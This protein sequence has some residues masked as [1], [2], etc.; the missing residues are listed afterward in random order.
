MSK[1]NKELQAALAPCRTAFI[2]VAVMSCIVNVLYLSGSFFMLEV[3]DRVIPSRSVPTLV[4]LGIILAVLYLFQA[5]IDIVRSR[6]L[7][8][9][10]RALDAAISPRLF[11]AMTL[12]AVNSGLKIDASQPGRDFDNVKSF[13]VGGGPSAFF[14]LPWM[15]IYIVICYLFHPALGAMALLGA[16]ILVALTR[17]TEVGTRDAAK[18]ATQY[19][20]QRAALAEAG[21]RNAEAIRAL[22]MRE[23]ISRRWEAANADFAR[24]NNRMADVSL[25]LGSIS[26]VAR[27]AIQSATLAAGAYLVIEQ[28]ATPGVMIACSILIARALAP[29]EMVIAQWKSFRAARDSWGRLNLL[30][31]HMPQN[32]VMSLPAPRHRLAADNISVSPPGQNLLAAREVSF[33]LEAGSA[34]GIIG[35]SASGKSS[36]AR[37]LVG[38][39]PTVRGHIRLDGA[40]LNQWSPERLG[41][42]IGY[43]P[44]DVELFAGSVAENIARFTP[45]FDPDAVIAAA[46]AAEVHE[47]I[48]MLPNGYDTQIGEHGSALSAGQRQRVAL[49]RAL[50]CDP[51]LVVLDEPNSNLDAEGEAALTRSIFRVRERG[52]IAVVVAHRPSA[53]AACDYVLVMNAG[54]MQ[55]FGDRERVLDVVLNRVQT[56]PAASLKEQRGAAPGH[57]LPP[58]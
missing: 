1:G 58:S 39:W 2:G 14:D 23:N 52:G 4:G 34:L 17:L 9:V 41:R 24:A 38:I 20:T 44:Q 56:P 12:L 16:L 31:D 3:Y 22:G 10:A 45:N 13:L 26:K 50:F 7:V 18:E 53:L 54:R 46:A 6:I 37:A 42:H 8:R 27:L 43:V 5:A 33:R 30:F 35:R 55:A 29:V 28:I 36:L 25:G 51:F 47:M 19:G 32:D 15:P 49:A 40:A 57:Q 21:R 48:L 11:E